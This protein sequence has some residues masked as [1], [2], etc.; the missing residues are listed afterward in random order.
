MN[1]LAEFDGID[2]LRD[3]TVHF[4][5]EEPLSTENLVDS[6]KCRFHLR[7]F[8][9]WQ[10][11]LKGELLEVAQLLVYLEETRLHVAI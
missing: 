2:F 7:V 4:L 8:K 6:F 3:F 1:Y 9:S 10:L 5:H 11:L